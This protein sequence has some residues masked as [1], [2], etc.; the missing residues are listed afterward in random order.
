[1]ANNELLLSVLDQI[2]LVADDPKAPLSWDQHTWIEKTSC[3][4]SMCF[5]GWAVHLSGMRMAFDS[6]E[7]SYVI[8]DVLHPGQKYFGPEEVDEMLAHWGSQLLGIDVEATNLLGLDNDQKWPL[9]DPNNRIEDL[10]LIVARIILDKPVAPFMWTHAVKNEVEHLL[11]EYWQ[12][13][14]ILPAVE[15]TA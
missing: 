9:F 1:M 15:V 5:A 7:D 8:P 13:L 10:D 2:H 3:G 11:E 4:T 6:D 12:D 14:E